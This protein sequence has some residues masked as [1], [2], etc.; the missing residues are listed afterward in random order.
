MANNRM[1]L[2]CRACPESKPQMIAKYYPS[3]G[4]YMWTTD[5]IEEFFN[6]HH[7]ISQWGCGFDLSF[8]IE[9]DFPLPPPKVC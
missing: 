5:V 7:H 3:T 9:P 6:Q 2:K 4:W 1:Y 8:E